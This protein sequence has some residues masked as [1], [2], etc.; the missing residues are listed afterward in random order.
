MNCVDEHAIAFPSLV[1]E[2]EAV[3]NEF[4]VLTARP[5]LYCSIDMVNF[6]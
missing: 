2:S 5:L 6:V 1:R 3:R 4:D